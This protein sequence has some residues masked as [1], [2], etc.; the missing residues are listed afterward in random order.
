MPRVPFVGSTNRGRAGGEDVKKRKA[1]AASRWSRMP[2]IW[3]GTDE[4][5]ALFCR[6]ALTKYASS[7]AA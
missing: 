2:N 3:K 4:R 6:E 5:R 1:R 7:T